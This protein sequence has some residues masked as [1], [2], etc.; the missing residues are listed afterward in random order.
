LCLVTK[1]FAKI[2]ETGIKPQ[3]LQVADLKNSPA[4]SS[5][6]NSHVAVTNSYSSW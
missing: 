3:P 6:Q 4:V 5:K 2:Q 1:Y